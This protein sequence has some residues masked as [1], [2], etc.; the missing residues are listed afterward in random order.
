MEE[1]RNNKQN[2]LIARLGFVF[3][4]ARNVTNIFVSEKL[5]PWALIEL[6]PSLYS[7]LKAFS[8]SLLSTIRLILF[9]L[10]FLPH[11]HLLI[12]FGGRLKFSA[13]VRRCCGASV[14]FFFRPPCQPLRYQVKIRAGN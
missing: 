2:A 7:P 8:F 14:I 5:R 10:H 6:I 1:Y 13:G 9:Y 4:W 12:G 3:F 11:F